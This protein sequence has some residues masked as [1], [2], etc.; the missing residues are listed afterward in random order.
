MPLARWSGGPAQRVR[1]KPDQSVWFRTWVAIGPCQT[2][3]SAERVRTDTAGDWWFSPRDDAGPEFLQRRI[4]GVVAVATRTGE[5][6]I[7]TLVS[8]PE[9]VPFGWALTPN[10]RSGMDAAAVE[11]ARERL[12]ESKH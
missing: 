9:E 6:G 12:S 2:G 1:C 3:E 8:A 11:V 10:A 5:I 7:G 4:G